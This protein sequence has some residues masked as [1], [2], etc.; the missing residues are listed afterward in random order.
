[1]SMFLSIYFRTSVNETF[2]LK[3]F[4]RVY[5]WPNMMLLL[6]L[7]RTLH[8]TRSRIS[9]SKLLL[10][11][12]TTR[13]SHFHELWFTANRQ[14]ACPLVQRGKTNASTAPWIHRGCKSS[15]TIARIL[16]KNKRTR[17][18]G[19]LWAVPRPK[20]NIWPRVMQTFRVIFRLRMP[21]WHA[22]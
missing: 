8:F 1:M 12:Y 2:Q 3:R 5:E 21:A 16:G 17:S 22:W 13:P 19:S 15:T 18:T 6:H 10:S 14:A 20:G 7:A 4:V 11:S 9:A